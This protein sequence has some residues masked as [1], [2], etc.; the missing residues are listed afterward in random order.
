MTATP[1]HVFN[2]RV[3]FHQVKDGRETEARLCSG[4]F[5]ECSGLEATME[6]K[7]VREGGHN[8]G[9]WQRVGPVTYS[10]VILKRGITR[11]Q[12]LWTW[13]ELVAGGASSVRL[14]ADL[15]QTELV[16]KG[17]EVEE[18]EL[19][20]WSLKNALPVKFKAAT[21]NAT[22]TEV[23]VEELHFVHEALSLKVTA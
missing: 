14:R 16:P 18:K 7:A 3:E 9:E 20:R 21:Y 17:E 6:P 5:S 4:A 1:L 13:F 12:D 23:G 10:T 11:A 8:F 22:A 15:I 19:L 2:F